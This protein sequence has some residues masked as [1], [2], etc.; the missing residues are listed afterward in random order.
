M[1]PLSSIDKVPIAMFAGSADQTCPYARALETK[2]IIG[3][4]VTHFRT[5]EGKDH[6]WFGSANK[7][8]FIDEL[9]EQLQPTDIGNQTETVAFETT[10]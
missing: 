1:I 5:I 7:K 4:A 3:D 10:E 6:G 9:I 2:D 8:W